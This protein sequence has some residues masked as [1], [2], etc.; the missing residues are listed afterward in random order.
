MVEAAPV[1]TSLT[2]L[3][4]WVREHQVSWET[5]SRR[6]SPQ[7]EPEGPPELE[8]TLLG[9]YPDDRSPAGGDGCELVYERLL[10]I[11]LHALEPI[12]ERCYRID[13]FDAAVR[14]RP[15]AGWVPEVEL[16]FVVDVPKHDPSDPERRRQLLAG[17]EAR[18]EQLGVKR[19]LWREA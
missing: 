12:P 7:G 11:A 2:E 16:T 15:E 19:Q 8:L 18:L 4:G 1:A 5:R 13:P 9:R 10:K 17:L 14:Y 3:E 6:E